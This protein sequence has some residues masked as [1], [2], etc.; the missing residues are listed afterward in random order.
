MELKMENPI[1]IFREIS[2]VLQLTSESLL[3][4]RTLMSWS[5]RKKQE[6]IFGNVYFALRN[7]FTAFAFYLHV[8]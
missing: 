1:H 4:I 3:K 5:F 2:L 7:F 6:F 8:W